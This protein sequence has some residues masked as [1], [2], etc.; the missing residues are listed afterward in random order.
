MPFAMVLDAPFTMNPP[1]MYV[2]VDV[3][4]VEKRF[5]MVVEALIIWTP[6]EA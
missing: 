2:F 6:P 5:A 1:E 3:A 4:F